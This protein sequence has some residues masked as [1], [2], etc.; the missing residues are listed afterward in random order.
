MKLNRG[1]DEVMIVNPCIPGSTTNQRVR[2]MRFHAPPAIGGYGGY[3]AEP[4]ANYEMIG[5]PGLP[6]A[7]PAPEDLF[8]DPVPG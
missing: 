3:Y 7:L 2:L 6:G 4:P 1:F 5:G 8:F